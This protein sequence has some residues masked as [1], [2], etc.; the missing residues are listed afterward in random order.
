MR[1]DGIRCRRLAGGL[2]T[3]MVLSLSL[4]SPASATPPPTPTFGRA[5]DDFSPYQPQ[6]KCNPKPKPGTVAFR[7][8]VLR[9]YPQ[10]GDWGISRACHIGG[11]SEHKEGR[12]WDWHVPVSTQYSMGRELLVWLL[13]SDRYGNRAALARRLG[14]MYI[15]YNSHIWGAYRAREGWRDYPCSGVTG[16]HLDHMHISF[17]RAGAWKRTSWWTGQPWRDGTPPG[18]VPAPWRGGTL[19]QPVG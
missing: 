4:A 2:G 3:A 17:S 19:P 12:A 18:A 5:I 9:A 11:T 16:C 15:I 6:T 10:T 7:N 1:H 8:M 13:A 14:V